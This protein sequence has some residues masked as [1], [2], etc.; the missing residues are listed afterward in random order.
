MLGFRDAQYGKQPI[1][2]GDSF[3]IVFQIFWLR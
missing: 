1:P 2:L 3:F